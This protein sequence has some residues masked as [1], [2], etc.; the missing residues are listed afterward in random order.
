MNKFQISNFKFQIS[1]LW[2]RHCLQVTAICFIFVSLN[3]ISNN[4]ADAQIKLKS[5][6]P[7]LC[8]DCHKELKKE[9]ADQYVHFLF[10]QGKCITCH[11]SHV[12]TVKGLVLEDINSLCI[13]CHEDIRNLL[14]SGTVHGAIRESKCTECHNAHSG[15]YKHIL[16]EEEK[17]LCRKCHEKLKD[18]FEKPYACL[19]FKESKCSSCHN[20]HAAVEGNLL[21]RTP[22]KLCQECHPPRCKSANVSISSAVKE[23]DCTSCHTGHSSKDKGLLGPY[24]H[25]DFITK[26]CDKCHNPITSGV[27]ITLKLEGQALCYDCHKKEDSKYKYIDSD[28]HVKDKKNSCIICHDYHASG[29]KNLTR[30]ERKLCINCHE[31]TERRTAF[32]EKAL[33]SVKC[34]PVKNRQCFECHIPMHSDRPLNYREEEIRMCARCHESQHKITHPLGEKVL[35]PRNGQPVTCNSCHSMHSAPAEFMLIAERSR[36]LCI[37]CHKM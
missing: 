29:K 28:V 30:N 37:Q 7:E 31:N 23:L 35:D 10:K 33:K 12:S 14:Q 17:T 20:P 2:L 34:V 25:L 18:Q 19:P 3:F 4:S 11:N 21:K 24:G 15:Q 6:I 1:K 32:M 16:V 13:G 27:K 36:A 8:Y 9:L 26:K 22:N 5:Q